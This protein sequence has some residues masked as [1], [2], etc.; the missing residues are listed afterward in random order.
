MSRNVYGS[1]SL[2]I[3]STDTLFILITKK[4][5]MVHVYFFFVLFLVVDLVNGSEKVYFS[6]HVD[7]HGSVVSVFG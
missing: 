2:Y 4:R 3:F 1:L 7:V 5:S 6:V